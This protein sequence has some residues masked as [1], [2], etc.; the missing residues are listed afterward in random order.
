MYYYYYRTII[1]TYILD[2]SKNNKSYSNVSY[3]LHC[4]RHV[5][6]KTYP[7]DTN[8]TQKKHLQVWCWG[9]VLA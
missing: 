9:R 5:G 1:S 8:E 3:K 6:P 4:E 7:N 2:I